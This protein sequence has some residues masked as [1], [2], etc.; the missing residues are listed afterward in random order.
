MKKWTPEED[1]VLRETLRSGGTLEDVAEKL[2]RSWDSV[3]GR[4][5]I[6]GMSRTGEIC[7]QR[8]NAYRLREERREQAKARALKNKR[9]RNLGGFWQA[10]GLE[11]RRGTH[12]GPPV[13]TPD[14][15]PLPHATLTAALCGDPPP[16]RSALDRMRQAAE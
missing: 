12:S 2:G 3:E 14:R 10:A 11:G 15:Y 4:C 7:P 5:R 6:L 16:G 8:A 9:E 1:A 13:V